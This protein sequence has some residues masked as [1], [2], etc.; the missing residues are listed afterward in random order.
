[1]AGA[2]GILSGL[3]RLLRGIC[4]LCIIFYYDMAG[5]GSLFCRDFCGA[6]CTEQ[7][8]SY[9]SNVDKCAVCGRFINTY[10]LILSGS[11]INNRADEAETGTGL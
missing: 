11:G 3:L 5:N 2:C 10:Q 6:L 7:R 4:G 1:M 8:Y 9:T